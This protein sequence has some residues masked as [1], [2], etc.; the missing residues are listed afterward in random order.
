MAF[1]GKLRLLFDLALSNEGDN[2]MDTLSICF[3]SDN[4]MDESIANYIKQEY[5]LVTMITQL[6]YLPQSIWVIIPTTTKKR[7]KKKKCYWFMLLLFT[8]SL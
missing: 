1:S 8:I 5:H 2:F 4:E 7:E 3:T 6:R